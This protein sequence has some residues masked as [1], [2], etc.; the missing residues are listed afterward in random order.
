[1]SPLQLWLF[2]ALLCT[3]LLTC[4]LWQRARSLH[5]VVGLPEGRIVS[6]D[7]TDWKRSDPLYSGRFRLTGKPDYLVRVGRRLIPVEVKPGRRAAA[8]YESDVLQLM[9][10]CLL[11]EE[12][13]GHRPDYGLLRYAEHT[14]QLPYN[15]RQRRLVLE[16]VVRMRQDLER[17]DVHPSHRD[18][19]RCRFCGFAQD[20]AQRVGG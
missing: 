14:F 3:L 18:P 9:T 11:V 10:Y 20:C 6:V 4:L 2:L 7:T 5:R 1:M 13:S 16:M 15:A 17:R 19:L 12:T 8:P